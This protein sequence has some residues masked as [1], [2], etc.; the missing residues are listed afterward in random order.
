MASKRI[1]IIG[2]TG[3]QGQAVIHALR[4]AS[5]AFTIRV[6]TRN[7]EHDRARKLEEAGVEIVKGLHAKRFFSKSLLSKARQMSVERTILTIESCVS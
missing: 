5:D 3:A 1:L 4:N 2:G 7:P 6:L